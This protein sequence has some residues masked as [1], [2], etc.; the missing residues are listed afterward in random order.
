MKTVITVCDTCKSEAY[1]TKKIGQTPGEALLELVQAEAN[2]NP[3][4]TVRSQSCLMG[5]ERACNIAIQGQDKLHYVLG[6]FE[7]SED[8]ARGIVEYAKLYGQS[9]SGQV[10][11]KQWP[12]EIKGHFVARLPPIPADNGE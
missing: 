5:C 12:Q 10:P 7:P 11:Y 6:T 8:A 3:D 2:A 9:D 4:L 1:Q